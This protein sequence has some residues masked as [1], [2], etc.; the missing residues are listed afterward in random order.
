M[1]GIKVDVLGMLQSSAMVLSA[2]DVGVGGRITV[3]GHTSAGVVRHVGSAETR[4]GKSCSH[5]NSFGHVNSDMSFKGLTG[6][7]MVDV[8]NCVAGRD[9]ELG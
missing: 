2:Q 1:G 6:A 8:P 7:S 3:N 5:Q 9:G 4:T